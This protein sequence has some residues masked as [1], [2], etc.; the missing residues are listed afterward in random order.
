M[1]VKER[2]WVKLKPNDV[3]KPNKKG[4]SLEGK[5][6]RTEESIFQNKKSI[7]YVI[8]TGKTGNQED[9]EVKVYGAALKKLMKLIEPETYV[10]IVYQG[11]K[12]LGGY[13][14]LKLYDVLVDESDAPEGCYD[15]IDD[16]DNQGVMGNE[17]P[18]AEETIKM[19]KNEIGGN[20]TDEEIIKYANEWEDL[21][22]EDVSRIKICLAQH[23]KVEG[24]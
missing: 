14:N 13:K 20:A 21:S 19:I 4:E 10:K 7:G 5:F 11:S 6:I 8:N 23:K 24:K 16:M 9:D 15:P 1:E 17:D 18:E 22:E 2:N 12:N 3:W